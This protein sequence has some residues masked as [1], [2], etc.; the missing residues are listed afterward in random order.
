MNWIRK[1]RPSPGGAIALGALVVALGGVAFAAIPDSNG[2]IHGCYQRTNGN[3]R[4]VE[5]P[6]DCR[7]RERALDWN[8][9]GP[10]GEPSNVKVLGPLLLGQGDRQV[11][12]QAGTLTFTAFCKPQGT[13]VDDADMRAIVE[14]TTSQDHAAAIQD[15]NHFARRDLLTGETADL[16]GASGAERNILEVDFAAT[17]PDRTIVTGIFSLGV[18]LGNDAG[19]CLIGGHVSISQ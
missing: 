4:V 16:R 11:L 10:P 8:R 19:K 6:D 17:S 14:I 3:L 9:Q 15:S 2:T 7:S 13:P 12:F 1:H 18:N 5:S